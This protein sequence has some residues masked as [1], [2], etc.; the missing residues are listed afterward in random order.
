MTGGDP[1][2]N[3]IP[4]YTTTLPPLAQSWQEQLPSLGKHVQEADVL[5]FGDASHGNREWFSL[6]HAV[7][8]Y[9]VTECGYR[10]IALET[11]AANTLSINEFVTTGVGSPAE[12]LADLKL[13]VWKTQGMCEVLTW[14]REFNTDRPAADQVR[15][16]G[17]SV[18]SPTA[19]ATTLMERKDSRRRGC[20]RR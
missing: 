8:P 18:G 7:I 13:W 12:A 5:G 3:L 10:T 2:S 4:E 14:L 19:P 1:A 20:H 6:K 16:H 11:A 15:F 17:V 9:L